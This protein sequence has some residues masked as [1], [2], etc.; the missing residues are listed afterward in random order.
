MRQEARERADKERREQDR[1]LRELAGDADGESD[2][3]GDELKMFQKRLT[4]KR[5][6]ADPAPA[7]AKPANTAEELKAFQEKIKQ[8]TEQIRATAKKSRWGP[9]S[10][11]SGSSAAH[12]PPPAAMVAA[13]QLSQDAMLARQVTGGE[14][15]AEQMKQLK[16]QREMNEMYEMIT[17]KKKAQQDAE[18]ALL[19][20]RPSKGMYQYDSDED[21]EGGTW[22]HKLRVKEM[23]AT[24]DWADELTKQSRG[25]HHLGDFLPPDE[26]E[27][28]METYQ[29]LKEGRQPDLSDYKDFKITCDNVG[30]KLLMNMG[31][32]EGSGLGPQ[33][34]GITA[35]VNKGNTSL[36]GAGVGMEK[37]SN[38]SA[39]DDEFEAY[40]KRMMLA[41]RFRPN[42]LNNPRRAY[43]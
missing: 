43:Y 35:P 38:L 15:S 27:K 2:D 10:G 3:G 18:K 34:Q 30:Y 29:A 5:S 4:K 7:A 6:A 21:T 20:G 33:K 36:D 37:P 40:R 13:P 25:K 19:T 17:K 1:K 16:Y 22:E 14:L 39:E 31:W 28:F 12:I 42:P 32:E 11:A 9:D 24:K 41:Y 26:L 23:S 8:Q